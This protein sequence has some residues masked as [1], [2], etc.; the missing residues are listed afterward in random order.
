MTTILS[1]RAT[2]RKKSAPAPVPDA[3]QA[4]RDLFWS[5]LLNE[6]RAGR[7]RPTRVAWLLQE[8]GRSEAELDAALADA[9]QAERDAAIAAN[10]VKSTSATSPAATSKLLLEK[11]AK[12]SDAEKLKVKKE[13]DVAMKAMA[14]L[15]PRWSTSAILSQVARENPELRERY[16]AAANSR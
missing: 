11:E 7:M 9:E 16:V 5:Q 3:E 1:Y 8:A 12:M 2:A 10:T 15:H 6:C 13:W 14:D 4:D